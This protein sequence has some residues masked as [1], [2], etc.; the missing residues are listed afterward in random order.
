MQT[1]FRE[2]FDEGP[3]F[4]FMRA[5]GLRLLT[6]A[7]RLIPNGCPEREAAYRGLKEEREYQHY[8]GYTLMLRDTP[9]PFHRWREIWGTMQ[10]HVR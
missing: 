5:L 2:I 4:V 7:L 1:A 10:A 6:W 8:R 3:K 9:L